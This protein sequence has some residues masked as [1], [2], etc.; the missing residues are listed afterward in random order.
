MIFRI[1]YLC[2]PIILCERKGYPRAL[3]AGRGGHRLAGWLHIDFEFYFLDALGHTL[4]DGLRAY[5]I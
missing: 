3:G 2:A 4:I 1:I 5:E